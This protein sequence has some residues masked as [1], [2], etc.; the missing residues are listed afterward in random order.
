MK[1]DKKLQAIFAKAYKK[2]SRDFYYEFEDFKNDAKSYQ[3]AMKPNGENTVCSMRVSRSGMTRHFNFD[4]YNMLFN[5]CY[6]EKMDWDSVK[7][8]GCGM[9]MHWYLK[10]RTCEQLFTKR[11]YDKYSLN[12][13]CSSGKIL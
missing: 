7:V 6:N 1:S 9:D 2:K 3:K 8:G 13:R 11:E 10:F 12:V 4:R 5:I